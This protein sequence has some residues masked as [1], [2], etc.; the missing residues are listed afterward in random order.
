MVRVSRRLCLEVFNAFRAG[1]VEAKGKG[2]E[3]EAGPS[4][5]APQFKPTLSDS[6]RPPPPKPL[7]LWEGRKGRENGFPANHSPVWRR[8][9]RRNEF[10]RKTQNFGRGA[11]QLVQPITCVAEI[12]SANHIEAFRPTRGSES[13]FKPRLWSVFF[14]SQ[15]IR[16]TCLSQWSL[17]LSEVDGPRRRR[18]RCARSTRRTCSRTFSRRVSSSTHITHVFVRRP[19]TTH[20]FVR[21]PITSHHGVI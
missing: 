19:I 11:P 3:E 6:R 16:S 15:P 13:G 2:S 9:K 8:V 21:R 14:R 4:V 17:E 18:T 7:S 20:V 12:L 1:E 5:V 10:F